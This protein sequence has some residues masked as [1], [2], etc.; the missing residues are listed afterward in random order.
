VE[1]AGDPE[2][3]MRHV[4]RAVRL[5][6]AD[7]LSASEARLDAI[8]EHSPLIFDLKDTDGRYLL[9]NRRHESLHGRDGAW[10]VGKLASD[11]YPPEI[12]QAVEAHDREVLARGSAVER[13]YDFGSGDEE[14]TLLVT[15]FPVDDVDGQVVAIGSVGLDITERRRAQEALARSEER[16]QGLFDHA[17]DM[18]F[19][20]GHDGSIRTVNEFGAQ[21]LGYR[22][23]ELVGAPLMQ[24][25]LPDD[26]EVVTRQLHALLRDKVAASELEF[27]AVR[28]DGSVLWVH[29]RVRL[30]DE[31]AD[32]ETELRVVCRDVTEARTLSEEL[33]YQASHDELT[34]L[35]NRR[36]LEKR[37]A[38]VLDTASSDHSEHALCY[39]DLDQFKVINDTCG[40]V[41]GDELL[42]QLGE[43]LP[44]R[45]RRRDTLARLGG[46]EFAVL[47]EH[48]SLMQARRVAN[49]LRESVDEFRF[50]WQGRIFSV[51]VSIGLVPILAGSDSV[52]G[53][54]RAADTA[55][56]VAK[57]QGRNRIHVYHEGDLELARRHG[58]MEWVSRVTEAV[59]NDGFDLWCQPIAPLQPAVVGTEE[60]YELLLRLRDADGGAILPGAFLP[61]AERYNVATRVDRWVVRAALEWLTDHLDALPGPTRFS[62]NLSGHS[63]ADETFLDFVTDTFEA[64][65]VSPEIICF[66]ITETAAI[67]NLA[68]ATRFIGT[69]HEAGCRFA[70]DDF[71]SGL[72]SFA[73]LKHLPVDYLK[74]DGVFVKDILDDP[75]DM[76]MVRSIYDVARAMNKLTI[77]EFVDDA[78]VLEKLREIGVHYAQGYVVGRPQPLSELLRAAS[79]GD[80]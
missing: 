44:R 41:A 64:T 48:C 72:S 5:H 11:L 2:D 70:L 45:V 80:A 62:I 30:S 15:K 42:R 69:L 60:H 54:L 38:R 6:I 14:R 3:L 55:C 16:Y 50:L 61:A 13:E 32:G 33:S 19:S 40:H 7:A 35:V 10:M 28:R 68:S 20:V 77:A 52:S 78:G 67:S 43:L 76:A 66:E 65:D 47:M 17:P 12:A 39:L 53:V 22:K 74:I 9:A 37:L 57:D 73:Y 63:I 71:G 26:R 8:V 56:Y 4:H 27:R 29:E 31:L 24:I 34:G 25:V 23:E 49:S 58:E 18:Y 46:D 36:E 59:E 1:K 79:V 75:I 21:Y 51:G